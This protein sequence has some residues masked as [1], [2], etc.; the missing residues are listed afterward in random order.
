MLVVGEFAVREFAVGVLLGGVFLGR[1]IIGGFLLRVPQVAVH[2]VVHPVGGLLLRFLVVRVPLDALVPRK[3]Q[4]RR[5]FGVVLGTV[6]ICI[7]CDLGVVRGIAIGRGGTDAVG[8]VGLDS[9]N[10]VVSDVS[11][12]SVVSVVS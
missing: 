5:P 9:R 8:L 4:L 3:E 10:D 11:I 2:V 6:D 1:A 12:V 7:V